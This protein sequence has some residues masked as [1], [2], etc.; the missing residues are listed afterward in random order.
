MGIFADD[1]RT[2]TLT[3]RFSRITAGGG[4]LAF[5]LAEIAPRRLTAL[6]RGL[7]R[8]LEAICNDERSSGRGRYPFVFFEEAHFHT[9]KEEI[10]DLITRGR[11]LGLTT[12]FIT[13]SP[14]EL[15]EVIFRQLDNLIVTG[16]S[17]SGDLRLVARCSLSDEDTLQ[18]L[19]VSLAPTQ[20]MIVGNLTGNFPLVVEVDDLPRGFPVSG[21]TRSFWDG[22]AT[23]NGRM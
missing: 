18:S 3:A 8:R 10:L 17:H 23:S 12:F 19:A 2:E 1:P 9:T 16:L 13:N 4:F 14:G 22:R 15:P 6:T 11:H 21:Q 7:N 5:D 20:A